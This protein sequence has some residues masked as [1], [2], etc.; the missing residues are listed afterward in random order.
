[1]MLLTKESILSVQDLPREL[2]EV[3]KWGGSVWVRGMTAGERDMFE[4]KI[5]T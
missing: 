1:M 5:R 2:V 4:D 3:A